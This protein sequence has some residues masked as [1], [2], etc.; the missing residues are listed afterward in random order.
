MK[1]WF[2]FMAGPNSLE[3]LHELWDPIKEHFTGL[4]AVYHGGRDDLEAQYL[5]ANKGEGIIIYLPYVGRHDQSR[6]VALH[7][8]KIEDGD[9]VMQCD[10]LERIPKSFIETWVLKGL[11]QTKS[12]MILYYGKPLLFQYH[13]SLQYVGT[14]HEGL[15]R[16]D[17]QALPIPLEQAL[18]NESVV[19][20]NVR[21][22]K[23]EPFHW[24]SH[25]ARYMMMPWGSNHGL[26]GLSDR[27]D[28]A[29]LFSE[30]EQRRLAFLTEMK[31][32]GYPRTLDG[33]KRM[34]SQPLDGTLKDFLNN[35]KVWQDYYR[36]HVQGD[37]T[38]IDEHKWTS[39]KVIT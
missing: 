23:R 30:R 38:V 32:R 20:L 2:T 33:L 8:G 12:N 14:P 7:C 11:M 24:V 37:K 1:L 9:W 28:P 34:L 5:E 31:R 6:N 17:G 26:L 25:Y 36:Y 18:P 16:Q 21:P 35:E 22:Q 27:G 10:T 19:R 15:R 29:K 3:D 39:M 4:C 13:E